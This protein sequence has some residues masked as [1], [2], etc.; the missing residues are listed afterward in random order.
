MFFMKSRNFKIS[1]Q[2]G[3]IFCYIIPESLFGLIGLQKSTYE[4]YFFGNVWFP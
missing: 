4:E 3:L 2:S 1:L